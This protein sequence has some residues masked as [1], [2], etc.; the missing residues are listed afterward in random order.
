M[1]IH[2]VEMEPIRARVFDA[3]DL[4]FKPREIRG[5]DGRSDEDARHGVVE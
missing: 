1:S 3:P 4:R 2:D 5:E